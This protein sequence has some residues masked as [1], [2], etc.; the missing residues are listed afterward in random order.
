MKRDIATLLVILATS[1]PTFSWAQHNLERA[2]RDWPDLELLK[3]A[4]VQAL[5]EVVRTDLNRRGCRIP[6]FTKWDARHNVIRGSFLR[7]GSQDVAVLCLLD[8]D[9]TIIVYPDGVEKGAHQIRRFPADAYRM[10]H[11]VS[12]FVLRKRA[13][14]DS[15]VER[16]PDFDHDGIDDGPVGERHETTYFHVGRWINVF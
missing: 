9:M 3:P 2:Q 11:G 8:D 6:I 14:R 1:L 7:R 15:A 10:I 16:L 12:P 13:I 5:A 4:E